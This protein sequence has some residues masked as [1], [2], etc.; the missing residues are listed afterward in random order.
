LVRREGG[1]RW[2]RSSAAHY[3]PVLD[4]GRVIDTLWDAQARQDQIDSA[5]SSGRDVMQKQYNTAQT[6]VGVG[7]CVW[8]RGH[9]CAWLDCCGCRG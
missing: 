8:V 9:S 4:T 1:S 7:V 2:C 5:V 6:K 3:Q